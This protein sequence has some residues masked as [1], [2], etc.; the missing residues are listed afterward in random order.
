MSKSFS[1][2]NSFVSA[3][4]KSLRQV[5]GNKAS[6]KALAV[7]DDNTVRL[8]RP[9]NPRESDKLYTFDRVF[10]EDASQTEVGGAVQEQ[11]LEVLKGFNTTLI[12]RGATKSGTSYTMTGSREQRGV[13]PQ[14]VQELFSRISALQEGGGHF[15]TEM[16][17][18]ELHNNVFHD[19]LL[20][21]KIQVHE[22]KNLG[23]FLSGSATLRMPVSSA[24]DVFK[25]YSRGQRVRSSRVTD[26]GHVS[27][28][29]HAVLVLH[30]ES[31]VAPDSNLSEE[32]E[33]VGVRVS[34][35]TFVDMAG[36]D[37][38]ELSGAVGDMLVESQNINLSLNAFGD[39]LFA[40]S[41][42]AGVGAKGA[43]QHVPYM[44]SKV[45]TAPTPA[46]AHH[47]YSYAHT[48]TCTCTCT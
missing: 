18:V 22:S 16:C 10:S 45:C 30:V 44:N 32:A 26:T 34:K 13:L 20:S 17:Y 35:L 21:T 43:P 41:K 2:R 40:L 4:T 46:P 31:R 9:N 48:C 11:L 28:R 42:N 14:V 8:L 7:D 24:A 33:R 6:E 15:Y 38:P 1:I 37:R 5:E 36:A 47:T 3:K 29:S 23:V 12:C 27:S 25:L 19:L 39:V